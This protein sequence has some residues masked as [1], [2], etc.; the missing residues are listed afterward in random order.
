ME[1]VL[2]KIEE[3]D[4]LVIAAPSW[5]AD[6]PGQFKVFID[7]CTPYGV[8]D[9]ASQSFYFRPR[10][11]CYAVALRA[12]T[13]PVECEHIIEC[14]AHWCGH[15][16]IEMVDSLYFCGINGPKDI[17]PHKERIGKKA[18]EWF[19]KEMSLRS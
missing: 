14:I 3:C 15:M 5:W 13:R 6:I 4:A 1:S 18:T 2:A 19:G 11:K 17:E 12:G 8:T 9:P 10:K 7:R 16:G